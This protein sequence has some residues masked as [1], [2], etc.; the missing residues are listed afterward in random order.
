[1]KARLFLHV[2]SGK[3]GTSTIQSFFRANRSVLKRK[4]YFYPSVPGEQR[5]KLLFW[6]AKPGI[7]HRQAVAFRNLHHFASQDE[8]RNWLRR[9]LREEI[10]AADCPNVVMS[11]E[12]LFSLLGAEFFALDNVIG[13][14]FDQVVILVYLRRQDDHLLSR[15]KQSLRVGRTHTLEAVISRQPR[16]LDY[17]NRLHSLS[18]AFPRFDIRARV[19]SQSRLLDKPLI[20]DVLDSIEID[21]MDG[22]QITKDRNQSLDAICAEYLRR[23]NLTHGPMEGRLQK[24]LLR[25]AN[26]LDFYFARKDRDRFMARLEESNRN[27]VRQFLPGAEDVFLAPTREQQGIPQSDITDSDLLVIERKMKRRVTIARQ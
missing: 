15:Y 14:L 20:T 13:D 19:Y 1:L 6:A 12:G 2:G 5:H 8:L 27:L 22:F 26:G 17:Y 16:Y 24:K 9:A 7:N 4:G 25:F 21:D 11:E 23:H 10:E 18:E 3:T